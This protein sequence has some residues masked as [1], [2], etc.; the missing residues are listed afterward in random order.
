M[1]VRGGFFLRK[2]PQSMAFP[3]YIDF[4]FVI[5]RSDPDNSVDLRPS[6]RFYNHVALFLGGLSSDRSRSFYQQYPIFGGGP[7]RNSPFAT[8][9][10]K[11]LDNSI[12]SIAKIEPLSR[13]G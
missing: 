10:R 3:G 5:T 12:L 6:Q 2:E 8:F 4:G 1:S 11:G 7:V 9:L 13:I